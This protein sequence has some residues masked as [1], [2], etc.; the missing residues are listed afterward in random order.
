MKA[1]IDS[2][3]SLLQELESHKRPSPDDETKTSQRMKSYT[4]SQKANA[5]SSN[6]DESN[7]SE[8]AATQHHH[9]ASEADALSLFGGGW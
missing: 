2:G 4:A 5:M 9:V 7:A 8:K 3:K 1:S 6:E